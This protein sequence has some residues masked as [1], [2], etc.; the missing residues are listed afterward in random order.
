VLLSSVV[1]S[2]EK[3]RQPLPHL[4]AIYIMV[5]SDKVQCSHLCSVS[6]S[7][8]VF[9]ECL[10]FCLQTIAAVVNDFDKEPH[11]KAAHIFFLE[12]KFC[13]SYE[14]KSCDLEYL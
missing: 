11:Y 9:C 14:S 6:S 5:P 7:V 10:P 2:L 8:R 1:E 4:E 12:S 13:S 3:S